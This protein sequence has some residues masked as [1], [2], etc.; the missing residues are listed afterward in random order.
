MYETK[1]DNGQNIEERSVE[2]LTP[3]ARSAQTH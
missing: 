2:S 1:F 3:Y